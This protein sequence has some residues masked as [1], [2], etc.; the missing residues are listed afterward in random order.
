VK[1]KK[2]KQSSIPR[3]D[4]NADVE[5]VAQDVVDKLNSETRKKRKRKMSK[6]GGREASGDEQTSPMKR[7]HVVS[8]KRS[9][10]QRQ[11]PPPKRQ[12]AR[13]ERV[14]DTAKA[15]KKA[16]RAVRKAARAARRAQ[17]KPNLSEDKLANI[18]SWAEHSSS[19]SSKAMA[20]KEKKKSSK[21]D[22][23]KASTS[24][25][26]LSLP[27]AGRWLDVDPIFVHG[28]DGQDYAIA[29]NDREVQLLSLETSLVVRTFAAPTGRS[30]QCFAAGNADQSLIQIAFDNGS[31]CTWDCMRGDKV[32]G[33]ST[34]SSP[35]IAMACTRYAQNDQ[36]TLIYISK[37]RD[38][39]R[40]HSE[41]PEQVLFETEQPLETLQVFQNMEYIVAHGPSCLILGSKKN[42]SDHDPAE[43]AWTQIS[44]KSV[45][46]CVHARLLPVDPPTKKSKPQRPGLSL[47]IGNKDGQIHLYDDIS[48]LSGRD[49]KPQLPTP[50]I[51][52]WHREAVSSV[53]FSQDGN[54]VISGG[55]ETVLVLWQLQT[56]KKQFLPH[57]TSAIERIV[58][59]PK[60][61]RYAIQMGDNSIMVLSTSELK[62]VA[63][64]AGL[65]LTDGKGQSTASAPFG[66]AAALHPQHPNQLLL[67]VP[68]AQSRSETDISARSFLQTF[69]L[70]TSRH[71]ARQALTRNNVTDFNVGP[72]D[73]PIVPPDVTHIALSHDGLWLATV[74]EWMPPASD[75]EHLISDHSDVESL[76]QSRREVYLKFWRWDD[77][78]DLWTLTT[79]ADSPHTGNASSLGSGKIL[80]L[81]SNPSTSGFATVGEDFCVK[82]WK[83]KKRTR[84]GVVL[85]DRA[86][87]ELMEWNCKRTI[88]LPRAQER[89]DSP[90]SAS[91]D[92]K[93]PTTCLSYAGDGSMLAVSLSTDAA[94][95]APVVHFINPSTGESI[96]KSGFA[97]TGVVAMGFQDQYFIAV[98]KLAAYIW[99]L[100]NDALMYKLK[101]ASQRG[102]ETTAQPALT[103]DAAGGTFALAIADKETGRTKVSVYKPRGAECQ[104]EETFNVP[105]E[106]VLAG[107]GAKGYTLLFSDATV[108]TLSP[109]ASVPNRALRS[110]ESKLSAAAA[111]V[112]SRRSA[113]APA[114]EAE[115]DMDGVVN[116]SAEDSRRAVEGDEDD[117]LVVRPEQLANIFD[118]PQSFALPPVREMFAAVV[119]LFG[120]QPYVKPQTEVA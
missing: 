14:S 55:R 65:Q 115:E 30:I 80:A 84:H 87:S 39:Y 61:D 73:T 43:F 45:A 15:A 57:L 6:N 110:I 85:K 99:D 106:A 41:Q 102:A 5:N 26:T 56:A 62:P 104:Y 116:A 95:Q 33:V 29:G 113:A 18:Q 37:G 109:A 28:K 69:D 25:W 22:G 75:L 93:S 48:T 112:E 24:R 76:R 21:R 13:G 59:N 90:F 60:G 38:K 12:L 78:E 63:N 77:K 1:A 51:L 20:R 52:H 96:P 7:Q 36:S 107:S 46:T 9:T 31:V 83:P 120:R 91:D 82:I 10:K 118:R 103:I 81:A 50:R 111:A 119:G 11:Q 40:I 101:L 72:E 16:E 92:T 23:S 67:S 97:A 8:K 105:V 35:M 88:Q 49:G 100:I 71:V 108:R 2:P 64:F 42:H 89:V 54:Y 19:E 66:S 94:D 114:D 47:A 27:I 98:S 68:S 86:D 79:R 74:D 117:R 70:A 17:T 44:L 53:K 58:V 34:L 4:A 3:A 32:G